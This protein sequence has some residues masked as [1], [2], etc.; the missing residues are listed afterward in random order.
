MRE[1]RTAAVTRPTPRVLILVI[2]SFFACGIAV[3]FSVLLAHPAGAA[4]PR[5]Q[6]GLSTPVRSTLADGGAAIVPSA[7]T[8]PNAVPA[9]V[10][11]TGDL[12]VATQPIAAAV[13]SVTS[14]VLTGLV[15][16]AQPLDSVVAPIT[17]PAVTALDPALQPVRQAVSPALGGL[18]T[19]DPGGPAASIGPIL[20]P[21]A[22]A[23]T[24]LLALS[25][26][27]PGGGTTHVAGAATTGA[28]AASRAG[29][30]RHS[31]RPASP[32]PLPVLPLVTASSADGA[33]SPT[34]TNFLA[35]N[36]PTELL[37]PALL[38]IGIAFWRRRPPRLLLDLRYAPPG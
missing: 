2:G 30:S 37:L 10:L 26:A 31:P 38:G 9:A 12:T 27:Q 1:G 18:G 24:Q 28:L 19:F 15:P 36:P 8:P 34:G 16:V 23:L 11:P 6:A 25:P 14:P 32:S 3:V 7:P 33:A 20:Q 35:A 17:S 29:T 5:E 21:V 22:Q 4:V 13:A